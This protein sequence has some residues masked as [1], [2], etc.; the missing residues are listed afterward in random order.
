MDLME[1][2]I[3]E[4][5]RLLTKYRMKVTDIASPF[6][7]VDAPG[8]TTAEDQRDTFRLFPWFLEWPLAYL[9]PPLA[10]AMWGISAFVLSGF[11][12]GL[13]MSWL[14][15]LVSRKRANSWST[16]RKSLQLLERDSAEHGTTEGS[17]DTARGLPVFGDYSGDAVQIFGREERSCLQAGE[18]LAIQE[19]LAGSLDGK[20]K[21]GDRA[22]ERGLRMIGLRQQLSWST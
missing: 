3:K 14:L 4:A 20:K 11:F 1:E 19:G 6:M 7:K 15:G 16:A 5:R 8:F 10:I 12:F 22:R 9:R 21:R 17:D 18:P 2:E 13:S